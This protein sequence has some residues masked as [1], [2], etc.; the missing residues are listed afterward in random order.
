MGIAENIEALKRDIPEHVRIV[1]AAKTRSPE[2]VAEAVAAGVTDIGEN[3]VQEAERLRQ[4]LGSTADTLTWHMIGHLQSNKAGK[5]LAVFDVIQTVDSLKLARHLGRRADRKVPVFIEINSGRE[6]QKAGVVPEKAEALVRGISG[7]GQV[8]VQGLM[9][10]GPLTGHA[11]DA[12]PCFRETKQLF[13]HLAGLALP[14]VDLRFLSMGMS[15][16]YRVAVEEGS[17]MIRPGTVVF[18][19]RSS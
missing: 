13:D 12:R 9:T 15:D 4:A 16:S 11:E 1:L 17:N 6:P 18:G 2:E 10:M 8:E 7:L 3:Y 19:P 5:A 14:D